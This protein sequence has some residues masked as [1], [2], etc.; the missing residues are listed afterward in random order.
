MPARLWSRIVSAWNAH[1]M[2][3]RKLVLILAVVFACSGLVPLFV[4]I[5]DAVIQGGKP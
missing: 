4:T 2:S 1:D 5:I 3:W